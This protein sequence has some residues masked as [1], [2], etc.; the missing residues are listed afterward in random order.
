MVMEYFQTYFCTS[1]G[2]KSVS[3]EA[4]MGVRGLGEK[5]LVSAHTGFRSERRLPVTDWAAS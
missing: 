2:L 4:V 1:M 3:A 5:L